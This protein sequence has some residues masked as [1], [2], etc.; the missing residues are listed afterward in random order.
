MWALN[1]LNQ[2]DWASVKLHVAEGTFVSYSFGLV[3][4][5]PLIEDLHL[6]ID[7]HHVS[8]RIKHLLPL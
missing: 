4:V 5:P 7:A 1:R 2:A 3:T 6:I 8:L